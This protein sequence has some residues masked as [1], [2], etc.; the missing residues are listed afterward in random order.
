MSSE[1]EIGSNSPA[2]ESW[3]VARILA[4]AAPWLEN[5][6]AGEP[7]NAR[8]ESE[9]L[10]AWALDCDRSKLFLQFD[11][12]LNKGE[13]DRF[14]D[15][16]KRRSD[17]EPVAYITGFRDFWR[18]RFE[19][20]SSV[21]IPRPD[22]EIL[23]EEVIA[24]A[25]GLESPA[26]LD[27]G[28]GSGCV[29]ISIAKDIPTATVTGWDI[30]DQALAI[31]SR[32][33]SL[34]KVDNIRFESRDATT[35]LSEPG[36]MYDVIVSNPPYIASSERGEMSRE[37]LRYEPSLALFSP[38]VDGLYFYKLFAAHAMGSLKPEGKIF[39]EV[40]WRQAAKVAQLFEASGWRKINIVK[41]LSGHE[42]V[43]IAAR[44]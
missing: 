33:A 12:P 41:D 9:L 6:M 3:T 42:R 21:L 18:Y 13:R 23:V 36:Q 19:V 32:N 38:D 14:K 20:N 5:R 34:N 26:I 10:L 44:D 15:A 40:G 16:I 17:C 8:L 7:C 29:G 39:L 2:A 30:S 1:S 43:V 37:T 31:A 35:A 25:K 24:F 28:V 11:R 27:V 22:T 4:W